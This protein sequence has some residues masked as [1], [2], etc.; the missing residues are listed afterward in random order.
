MTGLLV[1][2]DLPDVDSALAMADRIRPHVTGYKVGLE[3][4]LG[5]DPN[6]LEKVV[7]LGLPVFADAKLHDIP[8]TVESAGRQIGR[9][10]ARWLTVHASGGKGMLEAAN[11]GMAAGSNGRGGVLA[12]TVLTSLDQ[13][14]LARAGITESLPD[15]A[16]R[17]ASMARDSGTEGLICAVGEISTV[18][19][20]APGL[21]LITPGI[22]LAGGS[23]D[24][25]KRAAT[26]AQAKAAGADY[27]VVGRAITS[28][29]DPEAAATAAMA[30]ISGGHS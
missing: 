22:R 18:R 21:T 9:R 29:P 23:A 8:A 19:E 4:L 13:Q 2:L 17:M 1:A 24:D 14:D 20:G 10:G 15:H 16:R 28:S 12:V 26:P 5:P 7:A 27:I 25:Q 30:E 3:L 6:A 11:T